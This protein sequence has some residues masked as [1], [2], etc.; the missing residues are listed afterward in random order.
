MTNQ[1]ILQQLADLQ[2]ALNLEQEQIAQAISQLEQANAALQALVDEA[3]TAEERQAI[4]DQI[5]AIKQ[6][7]ESTIADEEAPEEEEEV[8]GEEEDTP[9]EGV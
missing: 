5:A 6:D 9:E 3:G 1:E 7:L 8:P 2:N 4:A